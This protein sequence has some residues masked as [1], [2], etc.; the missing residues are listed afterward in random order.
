MFIVAG[1]MG[2]GKTTTLYAILHE[3]HLMRKSITTIEDPIEYQIDK[4]NQ[5][6]VDPKR[7]LTFAV[8]LRSILRLDPDLILLG[9]IR[10]EESAAVAIEASN[11][12][13]V[14]LSTMHSRDAVGAVTSLRN[15][16]V[17][18][19]DI[20]PALAFVVSQR[21]VR[22]LCTDCRTRGNPDDAETA[23]LR[24][25]GAEAPGTTWRAAGCKHCHGTG[26][27]GRTGVFEVWRFDESAYEMVR[28]GAD[29]HDLR[30]HLGTAGARSLLA[31][32]L[33]IAAAGITDLAEV[34]AMGGLAFQ[35][36][37]STEQKKAD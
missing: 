12:G 4:I 25:V 37:V 34:R 36:R 28:G 18:N 1:P 20:A 26:Y 6:E 17:K 32:G 8:G 7:G 29:E 30:R 13:R 21:L 19:Q 33:R 24:R 16:G 35:T 2:S 11:T 23:W 14:L 5:I 9:E 31:N 3:M 10:D 22:K 27:S 15:L